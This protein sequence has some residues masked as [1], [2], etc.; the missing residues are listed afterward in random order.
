VTD[1]GA[2]ARHIISLYQSEAL[3]SAIRAAAAERLRQENNP[4]RYRSLV[5]SILDEQDV[6]AEV[7][8]TAQCRHC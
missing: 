5:G 6:P 1:P 8:S 2:F 7:G 4:A 3:W